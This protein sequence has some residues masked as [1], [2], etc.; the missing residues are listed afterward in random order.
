MSFNLKPALSIV[1]Q[2]DRLKQRG[3]IIEDD[4]EAACILERT[5]YYR[6]TGYAFL[7]LKGNNQYHR[8]TSFHQI[9]RLMDFDTT[10]RQVLMASLEYIEIYARTQIAYWFSL[11]HG[12]DGGAHYDPALFADAQFHQEY[13]DNLQTQIDRNSS[14]PFVAHHIQSF[15]GKM[16]LWS[17]VE[18]LSFSTL[19]K[20][21][22][23]M[24]LPDKELIAANVDT[25][26][27]HLTNWLHCFSVLRNACAHFSRLYCIVYSPKVSLDGKL[28]RKY[29]E[30]QQDTLFAYVIAMLRFMPDEARKNRLVTSIKALID[31]YEDTIRLSYIG[32]PTAWEEIL[33]NK[34]IITLKPVS[35]EKK[36]LRCEQSTEGEAE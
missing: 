26:V 28:L 17:A 19:S 25:D 35:Q 22:S 24:Q 12:R 20:L 7:F 29:S 27:D 10:L 2:V 18:I 13:L 8:G 32:F 3:L 9:M 30:I 15:N 36:Q 23:N 34:Q 6:F 5:N 21:Y 31:E 4:S 11:N 33:K 16:P 14:Q 1:E